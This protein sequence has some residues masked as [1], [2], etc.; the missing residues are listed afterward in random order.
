M[1][2]PKLHRYETRYI[3]SVAYCYISWTA[4]LSKL[5]NIKDHREWHPV[6]LKVYGDSDIGAVVWRRPSVSRETDLAVIFLIKYY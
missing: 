3:I 6:A 2:L 1:W 5:N 4:Y